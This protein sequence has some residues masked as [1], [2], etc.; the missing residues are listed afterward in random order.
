MLKYPA[1]GHPAEARP[2]PIL[3][4]FLSTSVGSSPLPSRHSIR[5]L[6]DSQNSSVS[7]QIH[8][9]QSFQAHRSMPSRYQDGGSSNKTSMRCPCLLASTRRLSSSCLSST[10]T[11]NC[12]YLLNFCAI[13]CLARWATSDSNC[14]REV[15]E[16]FSPRMSG[17][18]RSVSPPPVSPSVLGGAA[19]V[20]RDA[21]L[22]A[23]RPIGG[24]E[25]DAF[26]WCPGAGAPSS[27]DDDK[28]G[29]L[30]AD[31]ALRGLLPGLPGDFRWR[32]GG[33]VGP[34]PRPSILSALVSVCRWSAALSAWHGLRGP[35]G[36]SAGWPDLHSHRPALAF[37]SLPARCGKNKK[38]LCK[39]PK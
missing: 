30:T 18:G 8:F 25:P 36:H 28:A 33:S 39:G 17:P 38:L 10:I 24:S 14:W 34:A 19:S 5:R 3:L 13:G 31:D 12:S 9:S 32:M 23:P 15:A 20:S 22:T 37:S 16:L 26:E 35:H 4:A 29:P 6:S 2:R 11:T 21:G 1:E 7:G 27:H